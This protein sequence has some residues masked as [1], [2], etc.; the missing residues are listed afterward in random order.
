MA[1]LTDVSALPDASRALLKD[2]D[3]LVL[4]ALRPEPHPMHL[5]LSQAVALAGEIGARQTYF[6]HMAHQVQHARARFPDGIAL[7]HDGLTVWT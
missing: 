1:Y 3:V 7:A 5:S 4:G 2:L 6:V